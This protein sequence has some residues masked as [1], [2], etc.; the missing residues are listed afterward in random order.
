M[1]RVAAG[2]SLATAS[3]ALSGGK[4]VSPHAVAAVNTAVEQLGYRRN[5]VAQALRARS[6][7]LVGIVAPQVS[8][9][10]FAAL[11]EALDRELRDEDL[12]LILADFAGFGRGGSASYPDSCR[13]QCRRPLPHPDRSSLERPALRFAQRSGPVVQIDQQVDGV[14]SDYVGVDNTLGM[15]AILSHVVEVGARRVIFVSGSTGSR[16][17][18]AFE[19]EVRKVKGLVASPTLIGTFSVDFGQEAVAQLLRRRRLPDAIICGADIIALG[20]LRGLSDRHIDVPSQ[21]KVTGFDGILFAEFCEPPITTASQP[22]EAIAGEAVD[23]LRARLSGDVSPPHR[24]EIAP[25][26]KV[27]RSSRAI[28]AA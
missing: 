26:L 11:I 4:N 10:F 20:V 15:R 17:R 13:P 9:P 27:R 25:V 2:V 1:S 5:R 22:V 14:E 21:V 19:T 16:R 3:R 24:H 12:E 7:G 18:E 28:E 8:N 6:T 23:L